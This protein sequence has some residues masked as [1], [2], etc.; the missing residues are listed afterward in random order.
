[1]KI[2]NLTERFDRE[3]EIF[4]AEDG[5]IIY[6]LDQRSSSGN[7]CEIRSLDIERD[8]DKL[9][10]QLKGT[11]LYESFS[12]YHMC[13]DHFYSVSVDDK[14]RVSLSQIEKKTFKKTKTFVINPMGEILGVYPVDSDAVLVMD[15]T[16]SGNK[17]I[18]HI[19]LYDNKKKKKHHIG[20]WFP[21]MMI[22]DARI[23]GSANNK[24][25]VIKLVSQTDHREMI[26]AIRVK[27]M[28]SAARA[29]KK[30]KITKLYDSS[31]SRFKPYV[32]WQ[33]HDSLCWHDIT[34]SDNIYQDRIMCFRVTEEGEQLYEI[35][36]VQI[37]SGNIVYGKNSY[38]IY[39]VS[40]AQDNVIQV[41]C[42]TDKDLSFSYDEKYGEFSGDANAYAAVTSTYEIR[43]TKD[44]QVYCEM[45][46]LH[47]I[48][49]GKTILQV[50][51]DC[52]LKEDTVILNKNYL[53]L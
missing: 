36:T 48:S 41:R 52:I 28:I 30:A 21:G 50:E 16:E 39:E 45:K 17:Y 4:D 40:K 1:M 2:I 27:D 7:M 12:T 14:Y 11:R 15:E 47:D 32:S 38:H 51:G 37:P 49:S 35:D 8:E 34:D 26:T 43:N 24:T 23:L 6:A 13:K 31:D 25:I 9:L 29:N 33:E 10:I 18:T 22:E 19:Y 20:S 46:A 5:C 3:T 44:E 42:L 53:Y